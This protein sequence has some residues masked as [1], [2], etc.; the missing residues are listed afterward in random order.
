M[1]NKMVKSIETLNYHWKVLFSYK[2]IKT[3]LNWADFNVWLSIDFFSL[4]MYIQL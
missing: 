4:K 2:T 1:R 3:A